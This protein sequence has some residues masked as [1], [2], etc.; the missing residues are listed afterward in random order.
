[1][2]AP[3]IAALA[4]L[5]AGALLASRAGAATL[6]GGSIDVYA[7]QS[8]GSKLL[9]NKPVTISCHFS[10]DKWPESQP[11][12]WRIRFEVDGMQVALV[13]APPLLPNKIDYKTLLNYPRSYDVETIWTPV[14]AGT[15]AARCVLDPDGSLKKI[16]PITITPFTPK[17]F[18]V[19][20]APSL[21]LP[22]GPVGTMSAKP[23]VANLVPL[24]RLRLTLGAQP[25][26]N[27]AKN[28]VVIRVRG[29]ITNTG[30]TAATFPPGKLLVTIEPDAGVYGGSLVVGDLAAGAAQPVDITLK[31]KNMPATLAGA[32]LVL[33][34]WLDKNGAVNKDGGS[35][36]KLELPVDFPAG[37]C[38]SSPAKPP[39]P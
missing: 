13:D 36:L 10:S 20:V 12:P 2:N 39:R 15:H 8:P 17:S 1:M 35:T 4:V 23:G 32:H 7:V 38:K 22:K 9:T 30:S 33:T 21:S 24:P 16:T 37:Y 28:S 3:R 25:L 18:L 11:V 26:P 34:A 14:T 29:R 27:C 19:D 6:K 31:P 5:L